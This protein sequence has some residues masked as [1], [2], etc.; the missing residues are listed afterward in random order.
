VEEDG[1]ARLE[2]EVA[3][4]VGRKCLSRVRA[5]EIDEVAARDDLG[6]RLGESMVTPAGE[7]SL[8][9]GQPL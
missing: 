6:D 8:A 2:L 3:D 1:V 7:A 9:T 5:R 4:V